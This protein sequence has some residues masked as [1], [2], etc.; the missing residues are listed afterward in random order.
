VAELSLAYDRELESANI[1]SKRIVN[2]LEAN[3]IESDTIQGSEISEQRQRNHVHY[4]LD[5]LGNEKRGRSQH[6]TADVHDIVE[7]QKALYREST[8]SNSKFFKFLPEDD[9]DTTSHLATRYVNNHFYSGKNKGER[10]IR[11]SL[12][13]A[14]VAKRAVAKV[15]W[16]AD[17]E[18]TTQRF[19]GIVG[20]QLMMLQADPGFRGFTEI[21]EEVVNGPQGPLQVYFGEAAWEKDESF[22]HVCLIQPERYFRDP[23]VTYVEDGAFAGYQCDLSR[24][25]LIDMGFDEDQVMNLDLDYRFRQNEED[26]ARK[27][28]DS[29]W[30]RARRHKRS[31]EQEIVTVYFHWAY[32][33]LDQFAAGN[34]DPG[35][36][37]TKL[38]KFVWSQGELLTNP[39]SGELWKECKDGYPFVEWVQYKV[40]H[41]EFGLCDADLAGPIQWSKSNILRMSIDNI[42]MGNTSRWKARTGA[43]KN[44]REL[45]D[46]NIGS[47]IWMRANMQDLE[48]LTTPPLSPYTTQVYEQLE[49]DKETRTGLSRLAKGMNTDAIRYQN[50]DD[51][52]ER[53]TN[54]SNRRSMM[55]VRDYCSDFLSEIALKIYNLGRKY[56]KQ[57]LMVEH[58]GQW[59][60]IDPSQFIERNKIEIRAALTPEDRRAEAQFLMTAYQLIASDPALQPLFTMEEKHALLDD[61]FDHMGIGDTS[62]YMKQPNDPQVMQAMQQQQ[63]MN[64][65]IMQQQQQIQQMQMQFQAN[66]DR[67]KDLEL[68]LSVI[69]K[70]SDNMRAD[71]KMDWDNHW[72]GRNLEFDKWKF[73]REYELE[74]QQARPVA[75]QAG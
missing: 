59:Q 28:H 45:L 20:Q 42:A 62:R 26:A 34:T 56:D 12:H 66:E 8:Q 46:N 43:V 47:L 38:Y 57:P 60:Q 1:D 72:N 49:Q 50:A 74:K 64:Q 48:P 75:V 68:E 58:A 73:N 13:D 70:G 55:G 54:A 19:E 69:D 30:S 23:N 44:P 27:A 36:S 53:L 40:S 24:Y 5:R 65:A 51:M 4:A 31:P 17:S 6:I 61:A 63:M 3:V 67:R 11:D 10:I 71:E 14:F 18:K 37:G 22:P 25:Q 7:S 41:A 29:T 15:E 35:I 39:T 32:L 2:T 16:K 9:Q 21:R 33:D 52:V